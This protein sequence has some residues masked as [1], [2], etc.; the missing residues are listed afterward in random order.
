MKIKLAKKSK[1]DTGLIK[2]EKLTLA[3]LEANNR[4]MCSRF[5]FIGGCLAGTSRSHLCQFAP[6]RRHFL[7]LTTVIILLSAYANNKLQ[8]WRP[9]LTLGVKFRF[10][11]AFSHI[12]ECSTGIHF[13]YKNNNIFETLAIAHQYCV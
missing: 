1:F 13:F 7:N 4:F 2:L 10:R 9:I 12:H 3:L 6:D 8:T 5:C 11:T